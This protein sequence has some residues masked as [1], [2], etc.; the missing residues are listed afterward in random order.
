MP[1]PPSTAVQIAIRVPA[2]WLEEAERLAAKMA[3]PGM[4]STR[5]DVLRAAIA[6]GLDALRAEV[7]APVAL[8]KSRKR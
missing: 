8:P 3:R 2:E 6:K 4:T 5:S 7:D 1:R